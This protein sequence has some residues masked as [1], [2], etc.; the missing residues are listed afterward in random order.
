MM[1]VTCPLAV[2]EKRERARGN[3]PGLARGHFHAVNDHDTAYDVVVDTTGTPHRTGQSHTATTTSRTAAHLLTTS[4]PSMRPRP[5]CGDTLSCRIECTGSVVRAAS[6]LHLAC[7][8]PRVRHRTQVPELVG[9]S[10]RADR[11]DPPAEHIERQRADHV[12]V[13]IANNRARL[14]IHLAWLHSCVDA[15]EQREIRREHAGHV[16]GTDHAPGKRRRLAS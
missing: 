14:A 10:H 7:N 9:V 12:S 4:Q 8:C 2:A 3:E 13:P 15:D 5:S 11:L 1:H 6:L 16:V